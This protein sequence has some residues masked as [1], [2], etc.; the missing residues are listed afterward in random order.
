M[1]ALVAI[2]RAPFIL[3]A[4]LVALKFGTI[5]SFYEKCSLK[6]NRESDY[7][8]LFYFVYSRA[9]CVRKLCHP[10]DWDAKQSGA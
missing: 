7:E 10:S 5:R 8:F 3:V 9:T 4:T 6:K 1:A 2:P